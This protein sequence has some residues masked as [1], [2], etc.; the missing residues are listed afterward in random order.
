MT[1]DLKIWEVRGPVIVIKEHF[2]MQRFVT[3]VECKF[4][5]MVWVF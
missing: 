3:F 1:P 5:E 2:R 4:V